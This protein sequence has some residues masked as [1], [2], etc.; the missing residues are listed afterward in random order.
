MK[1]RGVERQDVRSALVTATACCAEPRER[2]RIEGRDRDGD[3]LTVVVTF[4]DGV[5]VV[6]LF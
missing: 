5:L 1:E 3:V 2:W 4:E 6:T